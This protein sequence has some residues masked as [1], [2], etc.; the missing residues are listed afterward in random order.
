[1]I[2]DFN[3]SGQLTHPQL[4]IGSEVVERVNSFKF[5]GLTMADDLTWGTKTASA[6][7]KAQQR[8]YYL[9][10]LRRANLPQKLMMNFY[11]CAIE[12]VLTYGLLV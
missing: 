5:L 4:Y 3:R 7:G 2:V 1:M 11:H 8:L 6:I 9:R 12:S 10:K